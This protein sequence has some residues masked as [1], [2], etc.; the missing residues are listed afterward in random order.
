MVDYPVRCL[1]EAQR[2]KEGKTRV[3]VS[4]INL[5][6]DFFTGIHLR[7]ESSISLDTAASAS[8]FAVNSLCNGDKQ[9]SFISTT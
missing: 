6:R 5:K 4:E 2:R 3:I 1:V 8:N 9:E 7:S